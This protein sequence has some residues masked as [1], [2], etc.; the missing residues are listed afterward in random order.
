MSH[1][2]QVLQELLNVLSCKLALFLKKGEA[3]F[4]LSLCCFCN[5]KYRTTSLLSEFSKIVFFK[6][7]K[8]VVAFSE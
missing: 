6:V 3:C 1:Y 5:Q 4:Y 7:H 2:T 8:Y